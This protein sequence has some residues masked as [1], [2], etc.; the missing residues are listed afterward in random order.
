MTPGY[1]SL[2]FFPKPNPWGDLREPPDLTNTDLEG[3]NS[4]W[5]V[6]GIKPK[7]NQNVKWKLN[8]AC[9]IPVVCKQEKGVSSL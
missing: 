1:I 4:L 3:R 2:P 5:E 6:L 8:V 9:T 7:W